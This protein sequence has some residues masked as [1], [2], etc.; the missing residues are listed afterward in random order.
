MACQVGWVRHHRAS[1]VW[2]HDSKSCILRVMKTCG[3]CKL[4]KPLEEFAFNR[5]RPDGRQAQCR[6]CKK[7]TDAVHYRNNADQQKA[8]NK[9]NHRI[10]VEYMNKVKD[11]P[12]A[13][14]HVKYMPFAMDFDH[15]RGTKV[16]N[17]SN[18]KGRLFSMDKIIEEIAKCEVVCANCHRIR[19]YN[20]M[21]A[22]IV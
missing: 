18:M 1:I 4:K 12:C 14:C 6:A 13:D 8:R 20:R 17:L 7:S 10:R 22:S 16:A 3:R 5:A 2:P 19:T 15:V 21:Q 11:V 9:A